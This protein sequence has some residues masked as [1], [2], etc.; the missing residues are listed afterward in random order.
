LGGVF[1]VASAFIVSGYVVVAG[2]GFDR[3]VGPEPHEDAHDL[4]ARSLEQCR[5]DGRINP[6][7]HGDDGLAALAGGDAE[8]PV[9][10]G[11]VAGH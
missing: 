9:R 4:V 5:G 7:G 2:G 10:D 1:R 3:I 6:A 8:P 11:I